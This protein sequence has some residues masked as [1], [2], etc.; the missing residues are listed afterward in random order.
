LVIL[1][2]IEQNAALRKDI[3]FDLADKLVELGVT[4]FLPLMRKLD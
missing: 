4:L 3:L 1:R 2:L